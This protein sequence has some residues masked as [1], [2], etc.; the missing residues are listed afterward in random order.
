MVLTSIFTLL[1][2]P[3][4]QALDFEKEIARQEVAYGK[5]RD[6]VGDKRNG[7]LEDARVASKSAKNDLQ[8]ALVRK[9]TR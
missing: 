9:K 5:I 2:T 1:L 3:Q 8:V 4:A 7:N 6:N